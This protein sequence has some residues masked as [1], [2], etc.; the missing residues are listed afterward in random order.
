MR[1]LIPSYRSCRESHVPFKVDNAQRAEPMAEPCEAHDP[2]MEHASLGRYPW[3]GKS[4]RQHRAR[5]IS[6]SPSK[7]RQQ[8]LSSSSTPFSSPRHRPQPS[9]ESAPRLQPPRW[10]TS[11]RPLT[12]RPTASSFTGSS[13]N[14]P[15]RKLTRFLRARPYCRH[16]RHWSWPA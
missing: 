3:W 8:L 6:V 10:V 12:V 13:P 7:R 11:P 5:E 2:S 9:S 15:K 16:W 4:S 14:R 1:N